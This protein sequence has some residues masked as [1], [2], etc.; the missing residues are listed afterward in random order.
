MHYLVLWP[1][2]P[3]FLHFTHGIPP[4]LVRQSF[5]MWSSY[6][7]LQHTNPYHAGGGGTKFMPH[8]PL[9]SLEGLPFFLNPQCPHYRSP[10][11]PWPFL[12]HSTPELPSSACT[13]FFFFSLPYSLILLGQGYCLFQSV[14]GALILHWKAQVLVTSF[15]KILPSPAEMKGRQQPSHQFL[16]PFCNN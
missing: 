16:K 10:F 6:P 8:R 4:Y 11:S 14:G 3:H 9:H 15:A 12:Y 13:C 1:F 5:E 2:F 7:H